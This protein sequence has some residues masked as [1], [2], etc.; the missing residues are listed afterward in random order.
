VKEVEILETPPV[1]VPVNPIVP[2]SPMDAALLE[3]EN[4]GNLHAEKYYYFRVIIDIFYLHYLIA[5]STYFFKCFIKIF[6]PE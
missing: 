1:Q 6:L 5:V 2:V 3:L 4:E